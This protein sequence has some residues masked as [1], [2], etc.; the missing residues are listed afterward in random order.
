MI[1]EG[2]G[3]IPNFWGPSRWDCWW[4]SNPSTEPVK[5]GINPA[6]SGVHYPPTSAEFL[7]RVPRGFA[8]CSLKR[9]K[10]SWDSEVEVKETKSPDNRKKNKVKGGFIWL[11]CTIEVSP[12]LVCWITGKVF[13]GANKTLF[14]TD[15]VPVFHIT[16]LG[17]I[18]T[19]CLKGILGKCRI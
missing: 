6:N 8:I 14:I 15:G 13:V 10:W 5:G 16:C 18:W 7:P 2:F 17:G 4:L 1:L 3:W 11:S 19:R 9:F 12:F